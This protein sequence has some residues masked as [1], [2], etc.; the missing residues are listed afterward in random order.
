M[1]YE[2]LMVSQKLLGDLISTKNLSFSFNFLWV[3]VM[4]NGIIING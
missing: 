4:G 1:V 3:K 2:L